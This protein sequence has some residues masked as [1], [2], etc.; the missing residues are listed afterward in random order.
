[1]LPYSFAILFF[2]TAIFSLLLGLFVLLQNRKGP[3]N[4][5]WAMFTLIMAFAFFSFVNFITSTTKTDALFWDK[6][7]YIGFIFLPVFF[8]H[9]VLEILNIY[10]E[11]KMLMFYSYATA[12]LFVFI[13]VF[14]RSFITDIGPKL[15]FSFWTKKGI[16][17]PLFVAFFLTEV[18]YGNFLLYRSLKTLSGY[19]R[20]RIR[21]LMIAAVIGY[22]GGFTN[23]LLN[24]DIPVLPYGNYLIPF[25]MIIVSY[26]IVK[27]RLMDVGTV[28]DKTLAFIVVSVI[29]LGLYVTFYALARTLLSGLIDVHSPLVFLVFLF[30]FTP[31]LART[32]RLVDK[33]FYRDKYDYRKVLR[34]FTVEIETLTQL[35]DLLRAVTR[36]ITDAMH[37]ERISIMLLDEVK[38]EYV[39]EGAPDLYKTAFKLKEDSPFVKWLVHNARLAEREQIEFNPK[40]EGIKDMALK[41]FRE[42]EAEICIPLM[43]KNKLIGLLNLG[44]RLSGEK[45]QDADFELLELLG[46]EIAV[47]VEN[48][49]LYT[50]LKGSFLKTLHSL[51]EALDAKDSKTSGHSNQVCKYAMIIG[52]QMGLSD[53]QMERLKVAALLHDIG[54]IGVSEAILLKPGKLNEEEWSKVVKHAEI[55]EKI[56]KPLGLPDEILSFIRHHHERY[57]GEGYPDRKKQDEIPLGARILCVADSFEAMLAER[58]YRHGMSK[59]EAV[60]ELKRCS[61]TQFDPQVVEGFLKIIDELDSL[62]R[63][64]SDW[65]SV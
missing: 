14:T 33:V 53:E 62:S 21:Y 29:I 9:F 59:E 48:A 39:T 28:V 49:R 5:A 15:G 41:A 23:F 45:Y 30:I 57:N 55:S 63:D 4:Q 36:T 35:E 20:E 18:I 44:R 51:V 27:Y 46:A 47:A 32:Q 25:S 22:A 16:S 19:K 3:V 17:Y 12:A 56:L 58:P 10:N 61:G 43:L 37:V 11:K 24:F 8:L 7:L 42:M 50:Q 31:L 1:M 34:A 54:K 52:K 40:Y 2:V 60:K 38:G 26:S 65:P 64:G 6:L 13:M